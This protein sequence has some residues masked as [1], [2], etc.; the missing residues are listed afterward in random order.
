MGINGATVV[1]C[2][3]FETNINV[4]A[5]AGFNMLTSGVLS[6]SVLLITN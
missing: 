2:N 3:S 4:S 5:V 1:I 6:N